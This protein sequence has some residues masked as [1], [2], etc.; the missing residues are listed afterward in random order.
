MDA[1]RDP[2]IRLAAAIRLIDDVLWG[3]RVSNWRSNARCWAS[4]T[5][6]ARRFYV[7]FT[8]TSRNVAALKRDIGIRKI[9]VTGPSK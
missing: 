1:A 2:E 7:E 4:M 3:L 6:R 8:T 5:R 9:I